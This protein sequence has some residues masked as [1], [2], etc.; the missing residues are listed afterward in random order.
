MEIYFENIKE[1]IIRELSQAKFNIF[2][3]VA[4]TGE[5]YI[6]KELEKCL[7]KGIQV[8]IILN[9][10]ERFYQSKHKLSQFEKKG[11]KIFLF[12]T[13]TSLMHNKFCVIDL[14]TTITG[15][16]NWTYGATFHQ[17]NIIIERGNIEVAHKFA[18]QFNKLK[19]QSTLFSNETTGF[20]ELAHKVKVVSSTIFNDEIEGKGVFLELREGKRYGILCLKTDKYAIDDSFI[21]DSIHG[22]WKS[23]LDV[24]TFGGDE[25]EEKQYYEFIC[26]DPNYIKF[27]A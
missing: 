16:F 25:I 6:I 3:A 22:F 19:K 24:E 27:L 18:I 1:K 23:K 12:D 20:N 9:D 4:W 14:C 17:E 8:E 15:S 10:D 11:G 5:K 26:I 21:P 7:N 2:I 13:Q